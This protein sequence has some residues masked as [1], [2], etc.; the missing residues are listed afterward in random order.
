MIYDRYLNE[1]GSLSTSQLADVQRA[2]DDALEGRRKQ[3][4]QA[5]REEFSKRA[6]EL[7]VGAKEL[8]G[9]GKR[10]SKKIEP[11]Y[12]METPDG[13]V[14]EWSGRGI[15]PKAFAP[16]SKEDMESRF[17]IRK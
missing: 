12:R 6:A 5:L 11:K 16:Y 14:H 15:R 1:F 13:K 7:G 10:A 3:E 4:I 2:L 9:R 17:L 8:F